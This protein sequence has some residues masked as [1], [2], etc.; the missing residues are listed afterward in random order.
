M[1]SVAHWKTQDHLHSGCAETCQPRIYPPSWKQ[2][3]DTVLCCFFFSSVINNDQKQLLEGRVYFNS[4]SG[5]SV[6]LREVR[7][8]TETEIIGECDLLTDSLAQAQSAS[9]TTQALLSRVVP[10]TVG[11]PSSIHCQARQSLTDMGRGQFDLGNSS[12]DVPSSQ[13][14]LGCVTIKTTWDRKD[15]Q[16]KPALINYLSV[17]F[18]L[19]I[20]HFFSYQLDLGDDC[21]LDS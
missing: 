3:W 4:P 19:S 15:Y 11:R 7:E 2:N 12:I 14:T 18:K 8:G 5:H 9:Y 16:K 20:W 21:S 6:S 10:S 1:L 13:V 17:V